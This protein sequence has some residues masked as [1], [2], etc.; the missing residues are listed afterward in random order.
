MQTRQALIYLSNFIYIIYPISEQKSQQQWTSIIS[1]GLG[2]FQISL[3]KEIGMLKFLSLLICLQM[4][5][6]ISNHVI[7]FMI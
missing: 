6:T 2:R 7:S 1:N 5:L 4:H 3:G